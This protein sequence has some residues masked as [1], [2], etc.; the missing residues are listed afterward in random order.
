MRVASKA[1]IGWDMSAALALA[2][3]L[4]LN[5]MVTAELLPD[6][7]AIMVRRLNEKIGDEDG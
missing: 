3:A 4:G 1:V 5:P 6:L 2:K 7:E